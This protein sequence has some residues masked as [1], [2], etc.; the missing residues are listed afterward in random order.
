MGVGGGGGDNVC[1]FLVADGAFKLVFAQSL[2]SYTNINGLAADPGE[3]QPKLILN[4][5]DAPDEIHMRLCFDGRSTGDERMRF[6]G[7]A[8][9]RVEPK[10][11]K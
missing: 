8:F 5:T 1:L 9:V 11:E 7:Q 2:A 4:P 10:S 6:D 3:C